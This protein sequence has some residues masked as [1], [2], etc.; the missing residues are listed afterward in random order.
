MN[1]EISLTLLSSPILSYFFS[2]HI[3]RYII[4]FLSKEREKDL[5]SD[6]LPGTFL[7]R[8]SESCRD[9]GITIT[10]VEYSQ[11][12]VCWFELE[13]LII[14][15][16]IYLSCSLLMYVNEC[17]Q[18]QVNLRHIQWS[19]TLNQI[20]RLFPCQ[21]SSATTPSLLHRRFLWTLSSTFTQTSQKMSPSVATISALLMV[22]IL[23]LTI[24]SFKK[25]GKIRV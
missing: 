14:Y 5:L 1:I 8:F 16:F 13:Y 9:G 20:W 11:D 24:H 10:W 22:D 3:Y 15:L 7:L 19:P 6:K 12:G 4:G 2:S 23:Y 17:H 18:I 21:T 25:E